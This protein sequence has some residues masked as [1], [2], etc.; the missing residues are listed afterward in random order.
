[1]PILVWPHQG[2]S[3]ALGGS[4]MWLA[5]AS[6]CHVHF[7]N[8]VAQQLWVL[9][10]SLHS[11]TAGLSDG[12]RHRRRAES[13]GLSGLGSGLPAPTKNSH[14]TEINPFIYLCFSIL[15]KTT[16]TITLIGLKSLPIPRT[17]PG[18]GVVNEEMHLWGVG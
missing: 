2:Q 8:V 16:T 17:R 18:L 10:S 11:G 12:R 14:G 9:H 5:P 6:Y 1:M 15:F 7:G 13:P 3:A 4:M